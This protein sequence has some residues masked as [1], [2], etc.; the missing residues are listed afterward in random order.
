M[1]YCKKKNQITSSYPN[2]TATLLSTYKHTPEQIYIKP[3]F[4]QQTLHL[5]YFMIL[6]DYPK[7]LIHHPFQLKVTSI[8]SIRG[9]VEIQGS[10]KLK[11]NLDSNCGAPDI[12]EP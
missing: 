5:Q 3:F 9:E 4:Y 8:Y 1:L 6:Y 2:Y 12:I 10:M 7:F 11:L